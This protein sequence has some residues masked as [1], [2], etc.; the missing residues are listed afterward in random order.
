MLKNVQVLRAIAAML[1]LFDHINGELQH[2][3]PGATTAFAPFRYI[4][5]AGVD[6]FFVISGF[7]MVTTSWSRFGRASSPG[8]FVLRRL[9]RIF[10]PYWLVLV[11]IVVVYLTAAKHLMHAHDGRG[12]VVA[13]IFLLPQAHDPLLQ[14][15]WTLTF[16]LFFYIVF[17]AILAAK[18]SMLVPLLTVW[19]VF[20]VG[21][22]SL[23]GQ[24]QNPYLAFLSTP[25]PIEFIVGAVV[26]YF[27]RIER[28]P[29]ATTVG[30]G[31]AIAFAAVW[32]ASAFPH[33]T[34][35][36]TKNDLARVVQFGIPAAAVVYGAVGREARYGT[37][38]PAW[39]ILLGNASYATYLWHV[40]ITI[41]LGSVAMRLRVHG[42]VADSIAQVASIAIVL[43]VSLLAYR[44]FERPVT[45]FLN[46]T[47]ARRLQ[48]SPRS[49]PGAGSIAV[50]RTAG[51]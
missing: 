10:P 29:F 22:R 48:P 25:L 43:A 46:A 15:S 8:T 21:A 51:E 12:D 47:I 33:A 9:A 19:F 13:S 5:N 24:T 37:A 16:E 45:A 20:E 31:G 28:L 35:D 14:V 11:P 17:A 6:L 34:A 7:I 3:D 36:L 18:R 2:S 50:V 1:V 23:I 44:Y 49:I 41:V 4:G 27:Y 40:P 42:I 38:A 32:L 26:G 30:V 39:A